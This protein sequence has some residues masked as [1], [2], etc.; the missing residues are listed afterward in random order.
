MGIEGIRY[1][2]N[3]TRI[4]VA[5][6]VT[7]Q[8]IALRHLREN[9]EHRPLLLLVQIGRVQGRTRQVMVR[10]SWTGNLLRM[11][12]ERGYTSVLSSEVFRMMCISLLEIAVVDKIDQRWLAVGQRNL[13]NWI[14]K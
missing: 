2:V 6:A 5:R 13:S 1:V 10:H 7:S 11:F 8:S 4:A 3:Y 12:V 14:Q 9:D